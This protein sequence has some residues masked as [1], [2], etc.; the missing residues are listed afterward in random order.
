[1]KRKQER[2]VG[3][4]YR[5]NVRIKEMEND[6]P[7]IVEIS[8]RKYILEGHE[9]KKPLTRAELLRRLDAK[10]MVP[11]SARIN[12][13]VIPDDDEDLNALRKLMN[14]PIKEKIK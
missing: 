7:I 1:M 13:E 6:V 9:E 12:W 5:P 8:K 11:G 4:L 10:A 14:I 2:K 3:D